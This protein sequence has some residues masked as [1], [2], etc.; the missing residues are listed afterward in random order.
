[1]RK[2]LVV[3]VFFLLTAC[4]LP[5]MLLSRVAPLPAGTPA[6]TFTPSP[7]YTVRLHPD[8]GLYTGDR[9]SIEVLAPSN[10]GPN[11]QKVSVSLDGKALGEGE[12]EP[13]GIAGRRQATF[14][15][16]W[17]THGLKAGMYTLKFLV[18]PVGTSWTESVVLLPADKVPAPEPGAQWATVDT[19][20]CTIHYITGTDAER[21]LDKLKTMVDAQA[22][23]D[24]RRLQTK[25]NG[26]IPITFM[27]RVLGHGGFT[28]D[29]IYVSYLDRNYAGSTTTQQV[30]HHEVVHWLDGQMG[31]DARLSMLEEGLAVYMSDGHFKVEPILPR[32]AALIQ[33]D[34]YVPL[35]QLVNSFYTSQHEIGYM[36]AAGFTGYMIQ[37][38]GWDK[39]N[40]FYRDLHPV[41]DG[42][43][44][45]ILEA[46]LKKHFGLALD[47]VEKDFK[48]FLGKQ[49]VTADD[50]TDVR[51]TVAFYD[52]ARRYQQALDPSAYFLTAW[53]PSGADMRQR[54]I[55]ADLLRHPN[56][57]DNQRIEGL[58]VDANARLLGKNY[59]AADV[60]I[61]VINW[62]LDQLG[63]R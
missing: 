21:D 35:P 50:L 26:K 17:D 32:A 54:G 13:Y 27:P 9:V 40:A 29:E 3:L 6:A 5:S 57:A 10:T 23:D 44:T 30:V 46:G 55:V 60:D 25:I 18:N 38:Y 11:Q 56:S 14:Y 16:V 12:F 34:W 33:L 49:S 24:E 4:Q 19:V 42:A 39:Y 48:A 45:D 59:S 51:L 28:S 2:I 1:M 47:Q 36:E 62:L 7:N 53:L 20:C 58:L 31:G 41:K 63:S 37:T 61:R 43:Q 22:A 15:W 8:G 52:T